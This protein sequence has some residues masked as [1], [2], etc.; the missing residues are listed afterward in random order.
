MKKIIFNMLKPI[1]N[2]FN[3][4][5]DKEADRVVEFYE[6]IFQSDTVKGEVDHDLR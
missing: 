5:A 3:R 2:I 6:R 4:I 1:R